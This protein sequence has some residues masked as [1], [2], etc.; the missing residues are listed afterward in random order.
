M[1]FPV[2]IEFVDTEGGK[3]NQYISILNSNFLNGIVCLSLLTACGGGGGGGGGNPVNPAFTKDNRAISFANS[4]ALLSNTPTE[5]FNLCKKDVDLTETFQRVADQKGSNWCANFCDR[6]LVDQNN[7][8]AV[9]G[10]PLADALEQ[11][12]VTEISRLN[13]ES[14]NY[15][16]TLAGSN[17][18]LERLQK[19]GD[20][21][22]EKSLPFDPK[23]FVEHRGSLMHNLKLFFHRDNNIVTTYETD[24]YKIELDLNQLRRLKAESKTYTEFFRKVEFTDLQFTSK[25]PLAR[26]RQAVAPFNVNYSRYFN[27][28]I[29]TGALELFKALDSGSPSV[30]TVCSGRL[31]YLLGEK[32]SDTIDCSI[33]HA[34]V[35]V[36]KKT[37]ASGC[38]LKVRNSWG[39]R[40]QD[41]GYA[42][43]SY[44]NLLSS[45]PHYMVTDQDYLNFKYLSPRDQAD[46]ISNKITLS[47]EVN[48]VGG[49][50]NGQP[51]G[52]GRA[53]YPSRPGEIREG[54]FENFNKMTGYVKA[55]REFSNG[56]VL[57]ME[58][59]DS[60]ISNQG[61]MFFA[62]NVSTSM[63]D[64]RVLFEGTIDKNTQ[65]TNGM[66]T[67]YFQDEIDKVYLTFQGK[68]NRNFY[69]SSNSFDNGKLSIY[70]LNGNLSVVLEGEFDNR[71]TL[72]NGFEETYQDGVLQSRDEIKDGVKVFN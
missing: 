8:Q 40:W 49:T 71:G 35:V 29:S 45:L 47:D 63:P 53:E 2:C 59:D 37:D 31:Q 18:A 38:K 23:L 26:E 19:A 69:L 58:G 66:R 52:F 42:W 34:V 20:V 14:E 10:T 6:D 56:A 65:E 60:S 72:Y 48:Y 13:R 16:L 70:E 44:K 7:Y 50:Y 28:K 4:Q 17:I 67:M 12:S 51:R 43:V 11:S 64:G 27:K 3:M 9:A 21:L 68:F 30:L 55:R 32:P 24:L 15:T 22:K 33:S 41:K 61:Q 62:G 1:Y 25:N 36:A 46:P 54:V 5:L 39:E 57:W